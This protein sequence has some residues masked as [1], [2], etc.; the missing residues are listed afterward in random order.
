MSNTTLGVFA[1]SVTGSIILI[2]LPAIFRGI[3][4]QPLDP[5]N[6]NTLLWTIMGYMVATAVLVVTFGRLGDMFGRAR[7][8]NLGFAIF[9][10]ASIALAFM[11]TGPIAASYLVWLRI[12][13]GIGGAMLTATS[14]AILVDAFPPHQ[15]GLAMG[16]NT[17]AIIGGQFIGLILG[18][19][20]ADVN[21]RLIFWVNVPIGIVGTLWS[22]L[23][24]KD[25][26]PPQQRGGLDWWGNITFAIGLVL[27]LVGINDGIQPHG[28]DL[29][30]WGS[31]KVLSELL[32]GLGFL[33]AFYAIEKRVARPMFNLELL[34]IKP[35]A[36]GIS[37]SLLTSIARGG[38]Q[39]MLII[40]LQGIWLP[41]HGYS[42]ESTPLWAGIF[43]LP[44][45]LGV[46]LSGPAAGILSDRYGSHRFAAGGMLLG[47]ATFVGLMLLGA[48]FP[49]PVFA[50]LLFI[51]GVSSGLFSAPN[52]TQIMN[53]VP[54]TERGQASGLRATTMNAGQVMSIGVFFT[55]MII[56]LA[57]SLPAS[58][59]SHLIAEGLPTDIAAQV[60][61]APPVASLFA[62]F[63]G[64]NPMGE[65]IP[66]TA[67]AALTPAQVAT[68]TGTQ[69]F[70]ELLS[71]PFMVGIKIAFSIS[72][73]LYLLAAWASWWGGS[74]RKQEAVEER[75]MDLAEQRG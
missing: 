32:V 68:I 2:S 45:T 8:Y 15:R 19:L 39:F 57:W 46:L 26:N 5:G 17:M 56:G 63:L 55:L 33:V 64:Y 16:I 71:G 59:Q 24:L 10:L 75:Q 47:A 58:M 23:S 20:L 25:K 60:A 65:L 53:A 72:F 7:I 21:W 52:G 12:I 50:L 38:L 14:T 18:G 4:L 29:M 54:A 37:A 51:N 11:P 43:M 62:A 69:F 49:Y 42:F 34:R 61:S 27:V 67:L 35:F 48:D 66:A 28:A 30:A 70:P 9:T 36:A 6:T 13:Q 74:T 3:G 40:W 1:A 31:P 41:I 44:L 73:V 22:Y